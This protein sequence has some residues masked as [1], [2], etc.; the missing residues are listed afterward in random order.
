MSAGFAGGS[1]FFQN[2]QGGCSLVAEFAME[3]DDSR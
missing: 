2:L 1:S 3:D